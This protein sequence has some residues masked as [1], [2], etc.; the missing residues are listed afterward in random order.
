MINDG[1]VVKQII[2]EAAIEHCSSRRVTI[3]KSGRIRAVS[4]ARPSTN[5]WNRRTTF[6]QVRRFQCGTRIIYPVTSPDCPF[7]L[8]SSEFHKRLY[9]ASHTAG[10]GFYVLGP[11]DRVARAYCQRLDLPIGQLREWKD[12]NLRAGGTPTLI[13][14]D[15]RGIVHRIWIG[16]VEPSVEAEILSIAQNRSLPPIAA[17]N[18]RVPNYLG[19]IPP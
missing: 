4:S 16:Q 18:R 11:S 6:T 15:S 10:E 3:S 8:A 7:C 9:N 19:S 17:G 5:C 12:L 2:F 14:V 1:R 13:L